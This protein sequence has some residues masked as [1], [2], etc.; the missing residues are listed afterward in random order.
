MQEET[1]YFSYTLD[2]MESGCNGD[3]LIGIIYLFTF[4]RMSPHAEICMKQKRLSLFLI[5]YE[6]G[7]IL[8]ILTVSCYAYKKIIKFGLI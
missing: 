3:L 2:L 7:I 4:I 8:N 5:I 1:I 6:F